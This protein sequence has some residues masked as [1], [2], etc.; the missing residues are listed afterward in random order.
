MSLIGKA[1]LRPEVLGN[2]NATDGLMIIKDLPDLLIKDGLAT[3]SNKPS[4][5]VS[6]KDTFQSTSRILYLPDRLGRQKP[7][8]I[9]KREA[10]FR[11]IGDTRVSS[12][13]TICKIRAIQGR[14][15]GKTIRRDTDNPQG[16][17][18]NNAT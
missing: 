5:V 13:C 18:K 6:E 11:G 9:P 14:K 8:C 4:K 10:S 3:F 2:H 16:S 1:G 17:P 7:T 15:Q 12:Y